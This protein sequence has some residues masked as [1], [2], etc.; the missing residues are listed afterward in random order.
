MSKY[1][2][3]DDDLQKHMHW[4]AWWKMCV[5]KKKGGMG[6]RDLH[7]LIWLLLQSS[8]GGC[9]VTQILYVLEF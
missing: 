1:W 9:Y 8:V 7:F 4:F 3:G 6:F 5:P 2:W